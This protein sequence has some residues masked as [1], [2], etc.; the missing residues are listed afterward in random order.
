MKNDIVYRHRHRI[1]FFDTDMAGVVHHSN[2]LRYMEAAR[3]EFLSHIGFPYH[4]LQAQNIGLAPV[5]V[6]IQY[7]APLRLGDECEVTVRLKQLKRASL[8]LTQTILLGDTVC[9]SAE[10]TLACLNE[11]DYKVVAI[12]ND[13]HQA[14]SKWSHLD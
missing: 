2:Y 9:T 10:V 12:P 13:L 1:Y 11:K 8:T 4:T 7:H 14:I 6:S 3:I 5:D